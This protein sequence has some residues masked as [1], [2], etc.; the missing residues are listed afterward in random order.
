MVKVLIAIIVVVLLGAGALVLMTDDDNNNTANG[1]N[2]SEST[3]TTQ[4]TD[5]NEQE[6]TDEP[7]DNDFGSSQTVIYDQNGFS[8]EM[9]TSKSG[10]K[11]K[12]ENKSSSAIEVYS[13]E[14][15]EHESNSELNIGVIEAG[16]SKSFT[17]TTKGTFEFH[18]HLS[19]DNTAT[20]VVQ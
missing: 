16:E 18:N 1:N 4:Q 2:T 12:I 11:M 7:A 9:L 13:G 5:N 20:V 14:H 3:D 6:N 8:P 15:P 10:E 17:L 19:P